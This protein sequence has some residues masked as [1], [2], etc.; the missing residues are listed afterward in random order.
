VM[1]ACVGFSVVGVLFWWILWDYISD[2]PI[3]KEQGCSI[4]IFIQVLEVACAGIVRKMVIFHLLSW[5]RLKNENN[6]F[7]K[8]YLG[9]KQ[10]IGRYIMGL[11]HC[12]YNLQ[13]L[14]SFECPI[15][16]SAHTY[17]NKHQSTG[18]Y[19]NHSFTSISCA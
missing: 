14:I 17:V 8:I 5:N 7:E 9:H 18:S 12:L 16:H 15:V 10:Q 6:T 19:S 2:C 4:I 1:D 13:W 3:K 11:Y